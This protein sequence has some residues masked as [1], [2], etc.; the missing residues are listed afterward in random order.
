MGDNMKRKVL[1]IFTMLLIFFVTGCRKGSNSD[2]CCECKDCP[3]CDVCC[4]C[5][6]PYLNK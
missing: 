1:L 2:D 6:H 5:A 4:S 3:G